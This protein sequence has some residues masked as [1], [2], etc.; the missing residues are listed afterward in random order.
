M[1]ENIRDQSRKKASKFNA[2]KYHIDDIALHLK[3][4]VCEMYENKALIYYSLIID[5]LYAPTFALEIFRIVYYFLIV[6]RSR[7]FRKIHITNKCM[8]F[9]EYEQCV[10]V[11]S[12]RLN[13]VSIRSIFTSK[14]QNK[15]PSKQTALALYIIAHFAMRK[16]FNYAFK[17]NDI[18]RLMPFCA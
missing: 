3:R 9:R 7:V 18:E 1:R 14:N 2:N 11:E 12:V 15:K 16:V 17:A 13:M 4:N 10:C 6:S 5:L 8:N